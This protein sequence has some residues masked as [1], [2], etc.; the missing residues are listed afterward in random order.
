MK[1]ALVIGLLIPVFGVSGCKT[2]EF[3]D[4][5]A[6]LV[7]TVE[8]P[9][10]DSTAESEFS[11]WVQHLGTARAAG[12]CKKLGDCLSNPVSNTLFSEVDRK[13]NLF[14]DCAD[15]PIVMRA[16][17]SFKK[18]LP[19]QY[20]NS[21]SGSH[22]SAGNKPKGFRSQESI[23]DLKN[24]M[25]TIAND[26]H[27]GFYRTTGEVEGTDTYPMAVSRQSL[28]PGSVFYD[29]NGHVLLVYK[30]EENGIIRL[31]DGHPDNSLTYVTFGEKLARGGKAQGGGF[32]N[33]RAMQVTRDASGRSVYRRAL[34][35]EMSDYNSTSQYSSAY[36]MKDGSSGS[37]HE[38]VRDVMNKN[39]GPVNPI[40]EFKERM[41]GLCVDVQDRVNAVN[42]SLKAGIHHKSHPSELPNNIY[43][44]DGEWETY[45][46]PSRDARLKASIREITKEVNK[47]ASYI[48]NKK[49]IQYKGTKA[50]LGRE[51]TELWEYYVAQEECG[52][53]YTNTKGTKVP[54][55]LTQVN[56]RIYDLSFDPYHCPEM[57]WGAYPAE[58]S[59]AAHAEFAT[60]PDSD[61]KVV[62]WKREVRLR[63]S[64][65]RLYGAATPPLPADLKYP[66]ANYPKAPE[67]FGPDVSENIHIP[68]LL[69]SLTR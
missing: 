37:Y 17:F 14:A 22:Y 16:Y 10:W 12:K 55:T 24:L 28:R 38:W 63:N 36:K 26:V 39:G 23:S 58:A 59:R 5:S 15:L 51:L 68:K 53:S 67:P 49:P 13:M 33:W 41:R 48:E 7:W 57:R 60:C 34:N 69:E 29:P 56:N 43:G 47:W 4:K 66:S 1:L 32:R 50:E 64:I 11:D 54:L 61:N 40:E 25:Q 62:W 42:D 44:T 27:S 45:S 2:R 18:K 9:N 21:I 3:N 35:S 20:V 31:I 19:F 52:A 65:D 6:P 30:V 46:T 8:R